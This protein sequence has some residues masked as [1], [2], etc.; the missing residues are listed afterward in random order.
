MILKAVIVPMKLAKLEIKNCD[1]DNTQKL[2]RFFVHCYNSTMTKEKQKKF[3][4][5]RFL[6][7]MFSAIVAI[8]L[9]ILILA[10]SIINYQ[11]EQLVATRTSEYAHSIAQI[12]A[13]SSADALLSGDKLQLKMLVENVAKDPYIRSATVFA[14]DGQVAAQYPEPDIVDSVV[15]SLPTD[16]ANLPETA[17]TNQASLE[18]ADD[19][20]PPNN[21]NSADISQDKASNQ[22]SLDE[23]T[24]A[25]IQS[26][27]DI[28]FIEKIVYQNVT[29][30][31][32]KISLNRQLLEQSFRESLKRSQNLILAIAGLLFVVLVFVV[33]R[34]QKRVAKIVTACH[35]LIQIN[36]PQIPYDKK[37]WLES[38]QELAETR[39]Q[40]LAEHPHLPN[41]EPLWVKSERIT[42]TL[43]CYC[44]FAMREQEDEKT[45]EVISL[46]EQ[47]LQSAI[48]AYGVQSQGDI[49][50]GCLIPFVDAHDEQEAILEAVSLLHVINES[51][52]SLEL[53][54]TM[55][56]F[57]GKGTLL[58][59]EN[60][61]GVVTGISLSNR[62][63]DKLSKASRLL[64]YGQ[65]MSVAIEEK[66]LASA[67]EFTEVELPENLISTPIFKLAKLNEAIKQQ[68]NRQIQYIIHTN[69]D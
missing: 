50:S 33:L 9:A 68:T 18:D 51:I 36:A 8:T 61:R 27:N 45:A 21:D 26:E 46:A 34:Y 19:A 55:K 31:W 13:N 58:T 12:A 35:R 63:K 3:K 48:Q 37:Q 64:D 39:F 54:I 60:A 29:A 28:P 20:Q 24:Q 22:P 15:T 69:D 14:E 25:Y 30:G 53:E 23:R 43:F 16:T 47:Y 65:V 40:S 6:R 42:N 52:A 32:F 41:E 10:W 7:G 5:P 1:L 59:L 62:L 44:E 56:G 4:E 11:I 66:L 17:T 67:G 57:M 38:L 49:L 2:T